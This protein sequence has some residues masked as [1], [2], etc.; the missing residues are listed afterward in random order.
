[1]ETP[2]N[3][4]PLL[5]LLYVQL[6][7]IMVC[8]K[9]VGWEEKLFSLMN[10]AM[11]ECQGSRAVATGSPVRTSRGEGVQHLAAHLCLK[12]GPVPP[13]ETHLKKS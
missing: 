7:C 10:T 5:F 11:S 1:M 2:N 8:N 4:C 13:G 3:N 9:L 12:I 6:Y